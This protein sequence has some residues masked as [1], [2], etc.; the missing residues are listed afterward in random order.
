MPDLVLERRADR[1]ERHVETLALA[2]EP[3]FQ[4]APRLFQDGIGFRMRPAFG[5][6]Q[7]FLIGEP[8]AAQALGAGYQTQFAQRRGHV[9]VS[10]RFEGVGG[11]VR[12]DR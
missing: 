1:V 6:G 9:A 5:R 12:H 2:R 4:L 7:Q 10:D 3:L 11:F 8:R